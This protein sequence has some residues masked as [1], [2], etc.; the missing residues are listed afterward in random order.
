[1]CE[2]SDVKLRQ[3][4][5]HISVDGQAKSVAKKEVALNLCS[6]LPIDPL[7]EHWFEEGASNTFENEFFESDD[8]LLM[9]DE[10]IFNMKPT[11]APNSDLIRSSYTTRKHNENDEES[12]VVSRAQCV[13]GLWPCELC[14]KSFADRK[15]LKLHVRMHFVKDKERYP[16]S[17]A[18]ENHSDPAP[19]SMESD[20]KVVA[21]EEDILAE[22][23][24]LGRESMQQNFNCKRCGSDFDS[25]N[26][27]VYHTTEAHQQIDC[28]ICGKTLA[29]LQNLE[30]HRQTHDSNKSNEEEVGEQK[31]KGKRK[32]TCGVCERKFSFKGNLK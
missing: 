16:M 1:M 30:R 3:I 2:E 18:E 17:C 19:R 31:A 29:T 20:S 9:Q 28:E 11:A 27:L 32:F 26:S 4:F 13:D 5:P 10:D 23:H 6:D 25:F 14:L 22:N 21:I 7:E 24:R 15:S 12:D 8:H